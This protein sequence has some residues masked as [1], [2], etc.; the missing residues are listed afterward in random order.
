[1]KSYFKFNM[2]FNLVD[3][4]GQ[5]SIINVKENLT[6]TTLSSSSNSLFTNRH[7]SWRVKG[8]AGVTN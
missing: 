7:C 8:K 5:I 6:A 1:M 3:T 2:P 4:P